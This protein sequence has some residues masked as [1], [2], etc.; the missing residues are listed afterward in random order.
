MRTIITFLLCHV[1]TIIFSQDT[2]YLKV[3][4]LYGSKPKKEYAATEAKWF[5][6]LLGGHVGI[7]CDSNQILNFLP[8]GEFHKIA[9]AN[10]RHSTFAL[11]AFDDFYSILG[12]HS[13]DAKKTIIYIP[14]SPAQKQK[15]DSIK[16]AYLERTPYDYAFIG[17]RCGAAAYDILGQLNIL[18]SH[19]VVKTM[20]KA[21]YPQLLRTQLLKKATENGWK[22]TREAGTIKRI[23]EID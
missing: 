4:F 15:L 22:I 17:M 13:K 14:I 2:V 21:F 19:Q 9:K 8:Q 10:D 5:G 6:G 3:H 12:G 1:Y 7:E 16:V 18:P 20:K 11:H 23:W